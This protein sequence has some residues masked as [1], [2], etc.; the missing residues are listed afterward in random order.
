MPPRWFRIGSN[1]GAGVYRH[2]R[3]ATPLRWRM[4][5]VQTTSL[6]QKL[7][8]ERYYRSAALDCKRGYFGIYAVAGWR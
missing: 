3:C 8:R 5:Q 7:R 2:T 4:K 1:R 6:R